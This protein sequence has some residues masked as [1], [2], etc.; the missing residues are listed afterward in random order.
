MGIAEGDYW[1]NDSSHTFGC[2]KSTDDQ[3]QCFL[4]ETLPEH[5]FISGQFLSGIESKTMQSN[6]DLFEIAKEVRADEDLTYTV[7]VVPSPF[8]MKALRDHKKGSNVVESIDR[9]LRT[10]G[11][12]GYSMDFIEPTQVED[13][14]ALF[15]SL[16]AMVRDPDYHP[17]KQSIKAT[18]I[19]E[20]K[21]AEI[22]ELLSGLEYWQF[23]FRLW[24][25]LKYNFIREEVAFLFGFSWSV[26]R[27]MAFE[28]GGRL[29][30]AGIFYQPDDIFFMRT[31]EIE[32]AIKDR[33]AGNRDSSFGPVSYTHLTLPT[34]RIV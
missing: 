2:A 11:H 26:L 24:L 6:A 16:K 4:R 14:S 33:E 34:K 30:K 9:Y 7:L 32:R 19:R 28:L 20:Q 17:S 22:T 18:A 25:A 29:V 13:P 10:Y 23:R 1:S 8:L 12:Q 5:N 27:P 31:T 21:L 15:A 3:L